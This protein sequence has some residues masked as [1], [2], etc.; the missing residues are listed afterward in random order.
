M[1]TST[2]Y[3]VPKIFVRILIY[4][5]YI[6]ICFSTP[7]S[8]PHNFMLE[9]VDIVNSLC[10]TTVDSIIKLLFAIVHYLHFVNQPIL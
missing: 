1:Y 6:S 7:L 2:Y 9:Q 5:M 10:H 8:D 3:A 4:F